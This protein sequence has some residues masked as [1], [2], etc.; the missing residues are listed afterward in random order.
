[1]HLNVKLRD[2]HFVFSLPHIWK[3]I[4]QPDPYW[5]MLQCVFEY[6]IC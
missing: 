1:M 5:F 2:F 6:T 3:V 4:N